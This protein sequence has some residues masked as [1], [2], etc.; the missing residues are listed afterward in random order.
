M[1][2]YGRPNSGWRWVMAGLCLV[3]AIQAVGQERATIAVFD[4]KIGAGLDAHWS[5]V[6]ADEVRA[7]VQNAA[8]Y[9]LVTR[10][11]IKDMLTE[12]DFAQLA[13][14]D[15]KE[16]A[17]RF[18]KLLAAQYILIGRV[19]PL[20]SSYHIT[21][22]L[23]RVETGEE[24][25]T[26]VGEC[27][28]DIASLKQ[29]S[30]ELGRCAVGLCGPSPLAQTSFQDGAEGWRLAGNGSNGAPVFDSKGSGD[31]ACLSAEFQ[32]EAVTGYFVA[33][34]QFKGNFSSAVGGELRFDL[35]T[36]NQGRMRNSEAP[37]VKLKGGGLELS[38][39]TQDNPSGWNTFAI[40]LS[41]AGGWRMRDGKAA[42]EDDLRRV[43]ANLN[44]MRIRGD[45]ALNH[46]GW[47]DN[48]AFLRPTQGR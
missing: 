23:F 43:L 17:V 47:I 25:A 7:V 40:P 10:D 41:T 19:E 34:P 37:L 24:P 36:S 29:K 21:V 11:R 13:D 6:L 12:I 9:R 42:S 31:G 16:C 20:G 15:Q 1:R 22:R 2:G 30:I 48:V 33:G 27:A 35:K 3:P 28:G 8:D 4:F 5:S 26:L 18:G 38:S 32:V 39:P 45:F 14:C 44:E 46:T